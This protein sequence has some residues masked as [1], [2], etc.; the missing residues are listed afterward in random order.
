MIVRRVGPM[1][2]QWSSPFREFDQLQREMR[3]LL[4][5]ASGDAALSS[6]GVFPALNVTQDA[7][8]FHVR[9][10]LPGVKPED[11]EI[12]AVNRTLSVSGRRAQGEEGEVSYHRRERLGGE[13]NRS[14]TLPSGFDAERVSARLVNGLLSVQL[15]KPE[16]AKPRQVTVKTS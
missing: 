16:A 1:R 8:N 4:D 2:T 12:S 5:A 13:F 9:A 3:R 6:A 11:L 10:E 14:V 15:P 7:D